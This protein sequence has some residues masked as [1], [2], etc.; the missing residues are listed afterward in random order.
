MGN[1]YFSNL[2]NAVLS[3]NASGQVVATTS[4]G[5]NYITGVLGTIN[6]TSFTRGGSI[7]VSGASSTLLSDNNTFSG[8]N[9]FSQPLQLTSTTGTTSIAAGQGFTVGAS[10]LVLQQG[11]GYVGIGTTTPG[12]LLSLNNIANFTAATSTFYSTGGINLA[13]GCFAINGS[14]L[15]TS[16]AS[17]TLLANNNTFSGTNSFTGNTTFGAATSTSFA[18]TSLANSLLSV[19]ANGSIIATTSIGTNLL[20]G[21]LATVNGTAIANGG[22][23]TITAASST[24]LVNNNTF[25]GSNIF[26]QPLALSSTSGTTTIA[27]G[28]GF[29]I[30][31]SQFL[32]QQGSGFVGIGTTSPSSLFSVGGNGFIGGNL[33]VTG[34]LTA[35]FTQFGTGAVA[36]PILTTVGRVIYADQY[37]T[38]HDGVTDDTTAIQN[39]LNAASSE[40]GGTVFLGPYQYLINSANL[41]I[42]SQVT[43][44]GQAWP[45]VPTAANFG[46]KPYTLLLNPS[47]TIIGSSNAGLQNVLLLKSGMVAATSTRASMNLVASFAGTAITGNG[48]DFS[49]QNVTVGGFNMCFYSSGNGRMV[50]NQFFGDCTNGVDIDNAHD[51]GKLHNVEFWSFLSVG[52]GG[53]YT[54]AYPVSNVTTSGSNY[55]ITI[56][57]NVF[58]TGDTVW[59][60]GVG[61]AV[62]ANGKWVATVVGPND[63]VLQNSAVAPSI[64]GTTTASSYEVSVATTTALYAGEGVSGT[65]IPS[66]DTIAQVSVP[67]SV[68]WLTQAASATANG[69]TLS[70]TNGTYTSGGNVYIDTTIR[71]GTAYTFTHSE[72]AECNDCSDIGHQIGFYLGAG[73]SGINIINGASDYDGNLNDPTAINL[74][75]ASTSTGSDWSG[76]W[77]TSKNT[78]IYNANASGPATTVSAVNIS[79][80]VGGTTAD[81]ESGRLIISDSQQWNSSDVLVGSSVGSLTM[82]GDDMV[83]TTMMPANSATLAGLSIGGG[84]QFKSTSVDQGLASLSSPLNGNTGAGSGALD[85]YLGTST[86]GFETAFGYNALQNATSSSDDVAVGYG[87]LTGSATISSVGSNTA[88]GWNT[89]NLNTSGHGNAALG[90]GALYRNTSGSFNIGIGNSALAFNTTSSANTGIGSSALWFS[91]GAANTAIGYQAGEG[92]NGSTSGSNNSFFGY[93]SGFGITTGI[94]NLFSGFNT[95]ST[96]ASGS[97]NIALGYDVGF[98]NPNNSN[99]LDIG[100]LIYGTGINGQGTAVSTGNI[101]IG[102]STPGSLLSLNGIANFA[103]GTSTL[104]TGLNITSGCYAINGSCINGTGASTTL[105]SD[106]NTFSGSTIVGNGTQA[107]GLTVSGGATTTGTLSVG[108]GIFLNRASSEPFLVLQSGGTSIGQIRASSTEN[109]VF[110]ASATGAPHYFDVITGGGNAGNVGIGTTSPDELLSVNGNIDTSG[111]YMI[112]N[113]SLLSAFGSTTILGFGAGNAFQSANVGETAIGYQALAT[114]TSSFEDTAIGYQA[115]KNEISNNNNPPGNTAIGWNALTADTYG[116]QNVAMGPGALARNTNGNYNIGIGQ[117]ALAFNTTSSGNTGIGSSA[118]WFNTGANNTAIGS[119]AGQG[120]NGSSSG[121]NNSF[122]GI[123]AGSGIT[124]GNAN[125]FLG[126]NTGSTTAT[127]SGNVAL[128]YDIGFVNPN[129]SNQLDIGNL[130]FGTGLSQGTTVSS[131]NI[132]IGTSTP[133]ANLSI[134]NSGSNP[135]FVVASAS[136][137]SQLLVDQSGNVGI[138]TTSPNHLLT[139][140]GSDSS[141]VLTTTSVA[142][143]NIV[144]ANTTANNAADIALNTIDTNGAAVTGTKLA[145]VFTSHTANA[146]SAD[147][148]FL[149]RT[150]GTLSEKMRLTSGGFLGIGTSTPGSLLSLNGIANFAAG[151]STLYTGL[152][153]TSGC[154][155]VNGTCLVTNGASSTLLSDNNTFSGNE[156]FTGNVGIGTS[157][158]YQAFSV[159]GNAAFKTT[160]GTAY[161]Q[162]SGGAGAELGSTGYLTLSGGN[163][164]GVAFDT[165]DT[166][167]LARFTPAGQLGIG[168]STPTTVLSFAGVN[169]IYASTTGNSI[170]QGGGI[171]L[172]TGAGQTGCFAIN[173]TCIVTNGASSTLLSDNNTFSGK[174]TLTNATSSTFAITGLANSILSVNANGTVVAT[175]SIGTNLLS[176]NLA[177][178]N[179]TTIANGGTYTVTAAS[180]TLLANSNTFSG[181][182]VFSASTTFSNLININQA[183]T[184]LETVG[185]EYFSNLP[186]AVL[187]TNANGQVVATTSI[188]TNILTGVLGTING[189]PLSRGGSITIST[190]SSTLLSDNDTFS[191]GDFFSQPLNTSGTTGGY[192]ID[193]NL[194]LQASSTLASTLI[195]QGAGASLTTSFGNVAVGY[196]AL[197]FATSSPDNVAIGF[198]ALNAFTAAV[199][200]NPG[201]VGDMTAVGYRAL[202]SSTN[203]YIN[204]AIGYESMYESTSTVE[205]TCVG[206]TS[207]GD[208]QNQFLSTAGSYNVGVGAGALWHDTTGDNNVSVGS[209]NMRNTVGAQGDVAVGEGSIRNGVPNADIGIGVYALRGQ[210]WYDGNAATSTEADDIAIG[211]YAMSTTS[212]TTAQYDTAVGHYSSQN[213]INGNYNVAFGAF[214]LQNA[215]SSNNNVAIG[216]N[217]LLGSSTVSSVGNN[218]AIGYNSLENDASGASNTALGYSSLA[219][220][221]SGGNNV[222]LGYGALT[223]NLAGNNN[224]AIGL[225]S[226]AN[227]NTSGST[228][229][230]ASSLLYST[231]AGNTAVGFLAGQ[232]V[233]GSSSGTFNSLFGY[234]SGFGLTTG[235]A[236]ILLGTNA[237]STTASGSFNIALGYDVALPSQNGSNQLDIGNLIYGTGINGQGSNVSTGNIGIG[238]TTP[239][240]IFAIGNVA[241]FTTATSTFYSTGGINLAGGCFAVGGTCINTTGASTTLLSD[242]NTF[243]GKN[244]FAAATSSS[245]AITGLANSLLSVNANGSIIAT[246]SI[247]TNLLTG[248]LGTVN[249]TAF[250]V[251]SSITVGGASTTLLADNNTFSGSDIFSAPLTVGNS[252]NGLTVSGAATTTGSLSVNASISVG[253]ATSTIGAGSIALNRSAADPFFVWSESGN[254]IAQ[255]RADNVENGLYFADQTGNTHYFDVL[256]GGTNAGNV[257]IGT[258]TPT[259]PLS[260]GNGGISINRNNGLD[261]YI[262][263]TGTSSLIGQIRANYA[264]NEIYIASASGG[265]HYADFLTNGTNA[266]NVGIG[267]TTPNSLLSVGNTNGINFSTATSTF[268]STGGI[269]LTSGCFSVGGTCI[270]TT[271]ASTT[272]LSNSNTFSGNN[273]FSASTTFSNLININQASTSLETIGN[274]Y[275]SNLSNAVLSTN[276]NGQVVATTS[277][278]SNLLTG[279]L[280]TINTQTITPGGTFTITAASSTLLSDNNTFSGTDVFSQPLTISNTT[281]TTTL[282]SGQGFTVG[283][284]QF[285]VQQGSGN[286]GIGTS[287][288]SNALSIGNGGISINRNSG[289]DP[290][291]SFTGTSTPIGQ[292]R[293][294]YAN[295]EIYVASASG[296]IHYADFLTGGT[297][298]GFVGIGTSTPGSLLSLNG[299]ANFT[300]AT[301]TFYS[302]GGINLAGG[303]FAVNG[304]CINVTGASTTLLSDNNTFSGKNTFGAATSSSFAITGLSNSILSVNANG[305]VVATTSIGINLLS[306]IIPIANGGTNQALQT[307]GGV[308]YFDGTHIT[309][310]TGLSFTGTNL[311]VGSTSP[312]H[313]LTV[314]S[315]VNGGNAWIESSAN[316]AGLVINNTQSGGR[317][318]E[319]DSAG[320]SATL[321][322]SFYLN[323]DTGVKTPFLVNSSDD[324]GIGGGITSNTLTG[325]DL[326]LLHSGNVGVG[327]STPGSLLS[328]NGIANFTAATSTFYSTGG[329]NLA[330]GCFAVGGI[331]IN[332]TGASSTLLSDNN[333]FSGLNTFTQ[334]LT[335]SNT[336]GTTTIASGQ[337]FTIGGSN[338]VVQQGTG[339]VGIGTSSPYQTLS[340][341]GNAAFKTSAGTAFIKNNAGAAA[342]FGSSGYL[343]LSA[344]NTQ[345]ITFDTNDTTEFARFTPNGAFGLGTTTPYGILSI[346][347]VA[348]GGVGS[349]PLVSIS[350]STAAYAT[351]TVFTIDK[352]GLVGIGTSTPGS[353]LAINGVGNFVANSTSTIYNGINISSGCFAVGGTCLQPFSGTAASSTLLLNNNTFSGS[354][355]FSQPLQLTSTTGTTTIASGQGFTVG[356]SQFVVQQGS[357]DV[358]VGTS[359]PF[360]KLSVAGNAYFGGNLTATG[361]LQLTGITSGLLSADSSGTVTASTSIGTS[362]LT[363]SLGTINGTGFTSGSAITITAASSTLLANSNTFSG[364]NIFSSLLNLNGGLA[365]FASSTIGNGT[366]GGGLVVSGGATTTGNAAILGSLAVGTSTVPNGAQ[367]FIY[368]TNTAGSIPAILIGGN[369]G[370]DTDFWIGRTNTNDGLNNDSLQFGQSLV[371]GASPILTLNYQSNVG[372]GSSTPFAKFSIQGN[373]TDP[374]IDTLLFQVASSTA[375]ATT[376]LFSI[377]NTGLI[378]QNLIKNSIIAADNNGNFI[379][380]T[381]IGTNLLAGTLATINTQAITPGGTFTITAAS[382]TLLAN[383]NTFS[384]SNIFSTPLQLT[385]TTGT[386]TI[387]TG[388]GFTIGSNQFVVQQGSGMVGV[389]TTTDGQNPTQMGHLTIDDGNS[390]TENALDMIGNVNDFLESNI[391][392]NSTGANAQSGYSATAN[393]GSLTTGF[394]FMGVNNSNFWNPTAYNVGG[395][396]DSTLLSDSND[397]YIAQGTAGK[398]IHILNGGTSTSTNEAL[399]ISGLNVGISSSTPGSL[400]SLGGIAN[401]TSA[402]STL[403]SSGGINI[404]NG[405]FAVGG[406][407]ISAGGGSGTVSSGTQG[408]FAFYNANGT[409]VSGTST[410]SLSTAGALTFTGNLVNYTSVATTTIENNTPY[411]W[412][413]ATSST[414]APLFNINTTSGSETVSIGVPNSDIYIGDVNSSPNLVFQNSSTIETASGG[415]VTL[416]AGSDTFNFGGSGTTTFSGNGINVTTGCVAVGGICLPTS[417]ASSTLLANNNT[418]SGNDIFST[419]LSLNTGYIATAS[420]TVVGNLTTTGFVNTSGTTG[421]YQING[422]LILQASTTNNSLLVGQSAGAGLLATALNNVAFGLNALKN[423]TTT[424]GS[425]CIG[426]QSCQGATSGSVLSNGNI[427]IGADALL[428]ITTGGGATLNAN[429]AVGSSSLLALTTGS[430]NTAVGALSGT[431]ITTGQSNALFG[432]SAGKVLSVANN[433]SFFGS[434]AGA[435]DTA[436]NNSAFGASAMIS[437]TTGGLNSAFG[438]SALFK[439]TTNSNDTAFGYSSLASTTGTSITG[440]GTNVGLNLVNVTSASTTYLGSFAGQGSAAG[441]GQIGTVAIGAGSG[442]NFASSS[443]WNTCVGTQSC[444]NVTSGADNVLIGSASTTANENLTTGSDNI[445]IGDNI[446]FPLATGSGQLDI[447]NLI[448]GSGLGSTGS[449]I[450]VGKVGIGTSTPGFTFTV[451]A[452]TSLAST[453]GASG[454]AIFVVASSTSATASTNVFTVATSSV[455]IG[456]ANG[457]CVI[458][459]S[460]GCSSDARLKTNITP[461]AGTTSLSELA[462]INGVTYNWA[463]PTWEQGQQVGVIAQNVQQAFPQLVGTA[464]VTFRG[465]SGTYYTVN[466]AGL[467]APL[468]SAVNQINAVFNA[469]NASTSASSILSYYAG[470]TTPALVIDANGDL[471]IGTSTAATTTNQMLCLNGSCVSQFIFATSTGSTTPNIAPD[472]LAALKSAL[473]SWLADSANGIGDLFAKDIYASNVTADTVTANKELCV[474]TVCVTPA[475]FQ[476]MVAAYSQ[477]APAGQASGSSSSGTASGTSSTPSTPTPPVISINGANPAMLDIGDTYS[478]LGATITGPQADTNLGISASVDGGATTT[479]SAIQID[480]T[481][482]GTHT[483]TYSVTDQNGLTG[484][485]SRT[486]TVIDPS[487]SST[488]ASSTDATSTN[489]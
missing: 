69:T 389:G 213:L 54:V 332:T 172:T 26:S 151:T 112:G 392:N 218:T 209:D 53:A 253:G 43:L 28:Q 35:P 431:A 418:F 95:A 216:Y 130:I 204:T 81:V 94:G 225:N 401:F 192:S 395:A 189:T 422:N 471:S 247:G 391:T 448:Y 307:S 109:A 378:N 170:F 277:I 195:G 251:G 397:L 7:T 49:V 312:N 366:Q 444:Y 184:S 375:S 6:G 39:A 219:S 198:D 358:G 122:F 147:T 14:C 341:N 126:S 84:T 298:A 144:N 305:S 142:E 456:G 40:G 425:I 411:A 268:Y 308:N 41:T 318:F 302:T 208:L 386:T 429:T 403:Y 264:N 388:Q 367:L 333:A 396:L 410:L 161:I 33:N 61:G 200:P 339:F 44:S 368:N 252:I 319:F 25:S 485:A 78:S 338:F 287:S 457:T 157:S 100:N 421:G 269:N 480:T 290:Y 299:I 335:L 434:S 481:T 171:N 22:T 424:N 383:N 346:A 226:L 173:G 149:N 279:T 446:S 42:P 265:V 29:T 461:I 2:P 300:A 211:T 57:T 313:A 297:N 214:T 135:G 254:T 381:S 303:C 483:I 466:Y 472:F 137:A 402:T 255:I 463:D 451:Q 31:G 291:I 433:N 315:T 352:N 283:S 438:Y 73:A 419:L 64:V 136:G 3:T 342:E 355:I 160:A 272:L 259:A 232:G 72:G 320:G 439:V 321:A 248:T 8:S 99:Q 423:A 199:P 474:G 178:V 266:G 117:A 116:F 197:Q 196:G 83:H 469:T 486:V 124:T 489:P 12:S 459:G 85:L 106:N 435:G 364:T 460:T 110:I 316:N 166:T 447:G 359:S 107:G 206:W 46:S 408:Q 311:G 314:V 393:T 428:S 405:C 348:G 371:P 90:A 16:G 468:I 409:T 32:L 185:N 382:S 322:S 347:G 154:F 55:D 453:L 390:T 237:A 52:F 326:T 231:G 18:I 58:Q 274:E 207:C 177:T 163:S 65:G 67:A 275:F 132:G 113:Q 436:S 246:T 327:T 484:T 11:S 181:N 357:G 48:N 361:T 5:S 190:A 103:V 432:V 323:D 282:A 306:G 92:V 19:N 467:T 350:S 334:P 278:G 179:G 455:T 125:L 281:G 351:S 440:V 59:V 66:G 286:V 174:T 86:T 148:V 479:L 127:G 114:A 336:T 449:N 294:N 215:T 470:S 129:N 20:T 329:I 310:G 488:D 93:N 427:G 221:T 152:N 270:G 250:S 273:L 380:T 285:V 260:I 141:T 143:M 243:S 331:C 96:T 60:T 292:I 115:L 475:Q 15:N 228:G 478:D 487:T 165:N 164:Q 356:G 242:N 118:L 224:V 385:S 340:V 430:A 353:V 223:A 138:G 415:T 71:N 24:L 374:S 169:G 176:G 245:F 473:T 47:Y 377:S 296:G 180:S 121:S 241:N 51:I 406:T 88:I 354:N 50:L 186:N 365:S 256:T 56:P 284:S 293:A 416:G 17:S 13:G 97:Y 400:L 376:S 210:G 202:A 464:P 240:S 394:M 261:P 91:T 108:S 38:H 156:N 183:S 309:S 301:S 238:T 77:M 369:P 194:I 373:P 239:G 399:T 1:E 235:A 344:G 63:I 45:G 9:I 289:L 441:F 337:G 328:L 234:Q 443:N 168:T 34:T 4:I 111:V 150:A 280:A 412:T 454:N 187:S 201:A 133:W 317:Q 384:G 104:Y 98:V 193:G 74:E 345:G 79:T 75:V 21:N 134:I 229:I 288:P 101:G 426:W 482:A 217:A 191:G 222:G 477:G 167:E 407:C 119:S 324:L 37:G 420:S 404:T 220:N 188:G 249:G 370:G 205:N 139:I 158:P 162:A 102:T 76:G 212:L 413:I 30:G 155:A 295:N 379:A 233:N 450:A 465:Q 236:N 230:G 27:S 244:I 82:T 10:Q 80:V 360:A 330:A 362:L 452:S 105:L 417:S 62:G 120:V 153:I 159:N 267:S 276:A 363:G 68:I 258:S 128:G 343:V 87:A 262:A 398:K 175:T 387:A 372:I 89:L 442:W 414:A 145:S 227:D 70:F 203:G 131:G 458:S 257:G 23:Y 476:A 325:A 140:W 182:N 271:G 123:N 263:F 146:V 445:K 36:E 437:N 462:L 349:L 304:S